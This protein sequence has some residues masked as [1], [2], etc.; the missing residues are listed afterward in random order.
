MTADSSINGEAMRLS[1]EP[2]GT[3]ETTDELRGGTIEGGAGVGT[4]TVSFDNV[5]LT[6]ATGMLFPPSVIEVSIFWSNNCSSF[7]LFSSSISAIFAKTTKIMTKKETWNRPDRPI[8]TIPR[9]SMPGSCVEE[10][11][12]EEVAALYSTVGDRVQS[13]RMSGR[14]GPVVEGPQGPSMNTRKCANPE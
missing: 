5:R 9:P 6:G 12:G 7:F 13:I 8:P 10:L 1:P 14:W 3:E 2:L 4:G 11:E